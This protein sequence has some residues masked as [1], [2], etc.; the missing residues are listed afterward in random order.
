MI[1]APIAADEPGLLALNAAHAV[2]LSPLAPA[3]LRQ[4]LARAF[5]ARVADGAAALLIAFDQDADY[6]SPNFAWFRARH[7]RFVYVDRVVVAPAARGR[8]LARLLYDDLFA[9]ARAAGHA[10]ACCEVNLAPPNPASD[11]FHAALGFAEVGRG[12]LA[13]R[14]KTVRYLT[15]GL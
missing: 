8:G 15:R 9:A 14:G 10:L 6:G 5:H 11:A 1:R 12:H 3:E 13:D 2:E 7:R 4:L